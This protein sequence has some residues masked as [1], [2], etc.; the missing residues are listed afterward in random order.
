M[1]NT[2]ASLIVTAGVA[3]GTAIPA[4]AQIQLHAVRQ[5]QAYKQTGDNTINA[6]YFRLDAQLRTT[7]PTDVE[8]VTLDGATAGQVN[9][10]Q[11]G[12]YWSHV[13]QAYGSLASLEAAYPTH[14][15]VLTAGGGLYN[16]PTQLEVDLAASWPD[17]QPIL[18]G[19]TYTG[20]NQ[21]N[22]SSGD[23]LMT[24]NSHAEEAAATYV[25]TYVTFYDKTTSDGVAIHWS[26]DNSATS[27]LL[28]SDKFVAG[29]EYYGYLEFFHQYAN[30][31]EPHYGSIK[32][33]TTT[34]QFTTA[35]TGSGGGGEVVP[36]PEPSTYGLMG[37]ASVAL[38]A[39]LRRR[40]ARAV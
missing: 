32:D 34:F 38:L 12:N 28:T 20:L 22:P 4:A 18:T 35:T 26:L 23:F 10:T 15:Y 37:A 30:S 25:M 36:V 21:W 40:K 3:F 19:N 2:I 33:L 27:L 8:W 17:A 31:E 11:N 6:S 29:H 5:Q 14:N 1:N 13:S 24:F 16:Q 7:N 9:L 39:Y